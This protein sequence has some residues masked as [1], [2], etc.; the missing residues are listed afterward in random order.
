MRGYNIDSS[1]FFL[2]VET[3]YKESDIV[4][5]RLNSFH[6]HVSSRVLLF[7]LRRGKTPKK[8]ES[9]F[10]FYRQ[11]GVDEDKLKKFKKNLNR[12]QKAVIDISPGDDFDV[13]FLFQW[14]RSLCQPDF[15]QYNDPLWYDRSGSSIES[16]CTQVKD[17][18]N[19]VAHSKSK[20]TNQD[21]EN[22]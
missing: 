21:L 12:D 9:L 16:L 14:I 5:A 17:K 3:K 4:Y 22:R 15:A 6:R 1:Y 13:T 18:R 10:E 20:L 11:L 8:G 19:F 7:L 2:A